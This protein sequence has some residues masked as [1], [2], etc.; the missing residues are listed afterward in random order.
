MT[1]AV[2]LSGTKFVYNFIIYFAFLNFR[3]QKSSL[4]LETF[5]AKL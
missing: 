2:G 3:L 1:I 5:Y 4:K